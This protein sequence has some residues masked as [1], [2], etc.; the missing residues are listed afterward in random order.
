MATISK[1]DIGTGNIVQAE[2]ITR[3]IDALNES[4]SAEIIA[5]GSFSGSF[6]GSFSGDGTNI[7]GIVSAS[8]A[9]NTA[10]IPGIFSLTGS[11]QA[12]T[13]DIEIT[14]SLTVQ[15]PNLIIGTTRTQKQPIQVDNSIQ[16]ESH[17]SSSGIYPGSLTLVDLSQSGTNIIRYTLGTTSEYRNGAQ[18]EFIIV[19]SSGSSEEFRID[20]KVGDRIITKLYSMDTAGLKYNG[21]SIGVRSGPGVAMPGDHITVTL[22]SQSLWYLEAFVS[23]SYTID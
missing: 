21:I 17:P 10:T 7:T 13:N 14:G 11:V 18:Y 16:I 20:P 4:G 22:V 15:P 3:I 23:G 1:T 12:T 8:Y 19:N 6:D 5:T 9:I 2:H